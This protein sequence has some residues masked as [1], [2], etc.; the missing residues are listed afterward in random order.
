MTTESVSAT[1]EKPRPT[2]GTELAEGPLPRT[3][4]SAVLAAAAAA[5]IAICVLVGWYLDLDLLKRMLPG[6]V[7]MNPTT[8]VTFL[9]AAFCLGSFS[10]QKRAFHTP[11]SLWV[12]R[13]C[14]VV[15][16]LLGGVQL[17]ALISGH[18]LHFDQ[19][20]FRAKLT[21]DG[22]P[23]TM[24]PNTALISCS[25]ASLYFFCRRGVDALPSA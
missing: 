3:S 20:L 14:A 13:V 15:V 6:L 10:A 11:R 19:W 9:I 2:A 21:A 16:A 18:D 25:P 12:G 1:E 23:N 4:R 17:V 7:A 22:V 5:A 8:A 24:A